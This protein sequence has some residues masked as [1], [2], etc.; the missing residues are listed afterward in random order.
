MGRTVSGKRE[1]ADPHEVAGRIL[2]EQLDWDVRGRRSGGAEA[3]RGHLMAAIPMS[4]LDAY[5]RL[6][7][8]MILARFSAWEQFAVLSPRSDGAGCTVDFNIPC[9]SAGAD[10]GL[11]VSTADEELTVGFHTHHSHFTDYKTCLN[12]AMVEAGLEQ[13]SDILAEHVGVVSW[14]RGGGLA[15][16]QTVALPHRNS[17]PRPLA[18]LVFFRKVAH[19]FAD[20]DGATL[21]S[22]QGRYDRD[23]D[24]ASPLEE[25]NP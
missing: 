15:G 18:G 5:S 14:Y 25:S 16:S 17:L 7:V 20:C 12:P 3:A 9:P 1:A 22:W 4:D 23:E 21:R 8:P 24:H 2:V 6:A 11:W 13:V 10:Y 19:M